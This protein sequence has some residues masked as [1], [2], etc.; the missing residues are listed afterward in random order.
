MSLNAPTNNAIPHRI[1]PVI[2]GPFEL[3]LEAAPII[4][5]TRPSKANGMLNQ[6]NQPR[7]GIKP[8]KK[9]MIEKT[10]I[11]KPAIPILI[12]FD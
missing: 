4:L 12:Q 8:I 2:A 3:S 1:I 6:L 11:I 7:K 5:I 9:P 10:P